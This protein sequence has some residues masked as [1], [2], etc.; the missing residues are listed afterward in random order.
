[1]F[2]R[3][4]SVREQLAEV[5]KA[6]RE[7]ARRLDVLD[8]EVHEIEAVSP[9]LGEDEALAGELESLRHADRIL[10][11]VA[12]ALEALTGEDSGATTLTAQAV[13]ELRLA[14]RHADSLTPLS[15]DLEAALTGLT[16]VAA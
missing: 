4:A 16:A 11:G 5:E 10:R 8:F 14:N 2:Q 15:N 7:R 3:L 12:A 6:Q 9:R 13:Q 1:A